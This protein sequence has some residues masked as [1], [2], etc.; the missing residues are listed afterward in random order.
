L[1]VRHLHVL[2]EGQTEEIVVGQVIQPSLPLSNRA[3]LTLS[4]CKTKRPAAASASRGGVSSWQKIYQELRLLLQDSSITTLTTLFDYYAFPSDAPGM[5]TR[6]VGS[7]YDRVRHVEQAMAEAIGDQR[8]LPHLVLHEIE[9]WVLAGC[10]VLGEV[11]GD[12]TGATDLLR[13][14]AQ[15]SSPELVNDGATTAPSKRI[16]GAYP[17]YRKTIDGPLVIAETG[18]ESIR[19]SCPHTNDWLTS[20]ETRLTAPETTRQTLQ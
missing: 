16:L 10:S 5:S 2:V 12:P 19:L 15:E 3:Y 1:T 18:L 13:M 17:N 7:P 20:I 4:I 14:V 6:P 9:A 8:F 11:M